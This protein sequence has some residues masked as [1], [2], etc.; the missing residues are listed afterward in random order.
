MKASATIATRSRRSRRQNSCIGERA[1]IC[2]L[3]RCLPGDDDRLVVLLMDEPG[4]IA[5]AHVRDPALRGDAMVKMLSLLR[6]GSPRPSR[7]E[8]SPWSSRRRL[9]R[10]VR[11]RGSVTTPAYVSYGKPVYDSCLGPDSSVG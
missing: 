5:G 3:A 4:G 1:V 11:R 9:P 10:G 2:L 6:D 8:R 7:H